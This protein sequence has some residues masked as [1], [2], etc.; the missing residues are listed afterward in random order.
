MFLG[1]SAAVVNNRT[2]HQLTT[3]TLFFCTALALPTNITTEPSYEPGPTRRGTVSVITSCVATLILCVWTVLH[4]NVLPRSARTLWNTTKLKI[5]WT[6]AAMFAPE[7]VLWIAFSQYLVASR[8]QREI[9]F[10]LRVQHADSNTRSPGEIEL[11]LPFENTEH[12]LFSMTAAYF[13]IMGGVRVDAPDGT[14]RT[15]TADGY[16]VLAELN[17]LP[18]I[19]DDKILDKNKADSIAKTIVLTQVIWMFIQTIA[20]GIQHLP[21]TLLE[22]NTL[23]HIGFA[24]LMYICW[25]SKPKDVAEPETIHLDKQVFDFMVGLKAEGKYDE[26]EQVREPR[27]GAHTMEVGTLENSGGNIKIKSGEQV[28]GQREEVVIT[29]EPSQQTRMEFESVDNEQ[30]VSSTSPAGALN[31]SS[32]VSIGAETATN[33][34]DRVQLASA[35]LGLD[36]KKDDVLAFIDKFRQCDRFRGRSF[37]CFTSGAPNRRLGKG[38]KRTEKEDM[39][40]MIMLAVTGLVY[41]GVHAIS[42]NW[43]FPTSIER[44]LWRISVCV[45]AVESMLM[46]VIGIIMSMSGGELAC[47]CILCICVLFGCEGEAPCR[48]RVAQLS[49]SLFYAALLV[50]LMLAGVGFVLART[51]LIIEAFISLRLLPLG[52]YDTVSWSQLLPHVT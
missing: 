25:W 20:R 22:L 45:V 37:K 41:S 6:L 33:G 50:C 34:T 30:S 4:L 2:S 39:L 48:T 13:T 5:L 40:G 18:D 16:V 15:L 27:V 36:T 12:K 31:E 3:L 1:L 14:H 28:E 11:G 38:S 44:S 19:T 29:T 43:F 17:M 24:F 47:V 23:A 51:Y 32:R 8:L 21:T 10:A 49:T 35:A 7:L 42:W 52:A 9:N 46:V 26:S